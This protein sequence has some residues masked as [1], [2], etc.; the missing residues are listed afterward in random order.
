M[1]TETYL[2]AFYFGSLLVA[3]CLGVAVWLCLRRPLGRLASTVAGAHGQT[4]RRGLP[5][6]LLLAAFLGFFSVSYVQQG[7]S[8]RGYSYTLAH[9]ET[10]EENSAQETRHALLWLDGT[11]YVW[12]IL[13]SVSLLRRSTAAPPEETKGAAPKG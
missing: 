8:R 11:V 13:V 5:L 6:S 2:Y 10:I 4:L 12:G 1:S 7:C 3:C 9:P